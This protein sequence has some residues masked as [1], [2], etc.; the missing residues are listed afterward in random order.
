[1]QKHSSDQWKADVECL[2]HGAEEFRVNPASGMAGFRHSHSALRILLLSPSAQLDSE[3]F[4][5][6]RLTLRGG[7]MASSHPRVPLPADAEHP[8]PCKA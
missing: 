7:K 5:P 2:A 6:G 3:T 8:S 1:M 4:F